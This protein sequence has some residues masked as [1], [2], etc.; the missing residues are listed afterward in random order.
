MVYKLKHD[1]IEDM[2]KS[3]DK[4]LKSYLDLIDEGYSIIFATG[5]SQEPYDRVKF[6]YRLKDHN[7]FLKKLVLNLIMFKN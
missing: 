5:L 1:P 4:I 2:L 3:Y 6:Y 7:S